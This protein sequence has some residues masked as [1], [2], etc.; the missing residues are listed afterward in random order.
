MRGMSFHAPWMRWLTLCI[1]VLMA[2]AQAVL[3]WRAFAWWSSIPQ[4]FPMHFNF[5]GEP[6]GWAQKSVLS[7]FGLPALSLGMSALLL[8]IGWMIASMTRTS[9]SLINVPRKQLFLALSPAG[10][11]VIV[12]PVRVFLM[13]VAAL[14]SL[15]FLWIVE[16]TAR[17]AVGIDTTL[18]SWPAFV[19]IG[20][21]LGTLPLFLVVMTMALDAQ[22]AREG[23]LRP[24]D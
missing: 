22:A 18:S 7:W 24:R 2:I 6:D 9:P 23:L 10:R 5:A 13:W 20:L 16:G 8:G 4:R 15:L 19:M 21:I 11:L 12:A 1:L 3:W 14:V 17:V